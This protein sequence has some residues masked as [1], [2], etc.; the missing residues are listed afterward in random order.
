[1]SQSV[2][3]LKAYY[4]IHQHQYSV[5]LS[6]DRCFKESQSVLCMTHDEHFH[7]SSLHFLCLTQ[8]SPTRL[9]TLPAKHW[10]Q[11]KSAFTWHVTGY[12][13][14]TVRRC[15]CTDFASTKLDKSSHHWWTHRW[16]CNSW[17][18]WYL[19]FSTSRR[20]VPFRN[21]GWHIFKFTIKTLAVTTML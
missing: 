4:S 11:C 21:K 13:Q 3:L 5:A 12:S 18:R 16:I 20:Y 9:A 2:S 8:P 15:T 17:P 10:T 6:K 19:A 14:I 7:H 1:M